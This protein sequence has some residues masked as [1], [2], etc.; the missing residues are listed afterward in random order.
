MIYV[1]SFTGFGSDL[2]SASEDV[3]SAVGQATAL[4]AEWIETLERKS[5]VGK[6]ELR[7]ISIST[8]LVTIGE[9]VSYVITAVAE[10]R[11]EG[12]Q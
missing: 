9:S 7:V 3:N 5:I 1:K 11:Q 6:L 8:Q 10:T 4:M 12:E 2:L